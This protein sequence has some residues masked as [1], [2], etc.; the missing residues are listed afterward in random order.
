MQ[1]D[2]SRRSLLRNGS[3]AGVVGLAGCSTLRSDNVDQ[4]TDSGT[5]PSIERLTTST[6]EDGNVQ[7][8]ADVVSDSGVSEIEVTVG[9]E[10]AIIY[11]GLGKSSL[12]FE[13]TID[14]ERGTFSEG[15]ILVTD[16]VGRSVKERFPETYV[17]LAN[18]PIVV[19][20]YTW[21][22]DGRWNSGHASDPS[23]GRYD[24]RNP[25]IV[26]RHLSWANEH[27][28]SSL[29]VSWWGPE[30]ENTD[31]FE[32][33]VL[34]VDWPND[35][36]YCILY[37]PNGDTGGRLEYKDGTADLDSRVNRN[38]LQ[39][40][41][42]Y[43][44]DEYFTDDRYFE[45]DNRPVLYVWI[46]TTFEGDVKKAVENATDVAG[47]DPYLIADV[48]VLRQ[49]QIVGTPLAE[50]FD[51]VTSYITIPEKDHGH[52]ENVDFESFL[53]DVDRSFT[54]WRLAAES[55]GLDFFPVV[56]PGYTEYGDNENQVYP[57]NQEWFAK[58][59]EVAINQV[60]PG[61]EGIFITSFN[62]W[63]E[64]SHIEPDT[65]DGLDFLDVVNEKLANGDP[66]P[67]TNSIQPMTFTFNETVR[68]SQTTP[69]SD[70]DREL[71]FACDKLVFFDTNGDVLTE[72][73][74]GTASEPM[75]VD[76]V[77]YTESDDNRTWRWFGGP[78]ATSI[79]GLDGDLLAEMAEIKL[80]GRAITDNLQA[81]IDANEWAT[82][83][84]LSEG[85]D[86]YMFSV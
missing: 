76:G 52:G 71:A 54:R 66:K 36:E 34:S 22:F 46:A 19:P 39:S 70:D 11:D 32:N 79:L 3:I 42:E 83:L 12:G 57:R 23:L 29:C 15:D 38:R 45:I 82:T 17:P 50:T 48:P 33:S 1:F 86:R 67:D 27:G 8:F 85:W 75:L 21:Y 31:A 81:R 10:T 44:A 51:A 40:D 14:A 63:H 24:S 73:D 9:G 26:N 61:F 64:D 7:V 30:N 60:Q 25:A 65:T 43:I 20:Y 18:R 74:I 47:V 84:E 28:I 62:E 78:G 13:T 69:D 2:R 68:P 77:S 49:P 53:N 4:Q 56:Q 16:E 5:S 80:V 59:C 35:L 58:I 6:T 37:E 41:I 55:V 72:F